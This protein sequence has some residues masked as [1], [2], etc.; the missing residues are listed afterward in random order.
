[1]L[2]GKERCHGAA[3]V[4]GADDRDV[5]GGSHFVMFV[6]L[7]TILCSSRRYHIPGSNDTIVVV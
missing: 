4:S 1:V 3:H 2:L 5:L 6:T 7:F